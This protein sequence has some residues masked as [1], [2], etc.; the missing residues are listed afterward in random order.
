MRRRTAILLALVTGVLVVVMA[1]AF[2]LIQTLRTAS[3]TRSGDPGYAN[4]RALPVDSPVKLGRNGFINTAD[5][6]AS[7]AWRWRALRG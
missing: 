2:A 5:P 3:E 4:E 7:C 1:L 6:A